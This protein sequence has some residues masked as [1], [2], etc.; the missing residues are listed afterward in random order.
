[1]SLL[2]IASKVTAAALIATLTIPLSMFA[3]AKEPVFRLRDLGQIV[4]SAQRVAPP[5]AAERAVESPF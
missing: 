2:Q 4:L 5:A 3:Q 1:M